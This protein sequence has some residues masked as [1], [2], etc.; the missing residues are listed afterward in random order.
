MQPMSLFAKGFR[1]FFLCAVCLAGS[2]VVYW[3]LLFLGRVPS[4]SL[5]YYPPI[6][7]H[8]H[9]MVFGYIGAVIAGFLLTAV[10]NWT[11]RITLQGWPLAILFLIWVGARV[12][13]FVGDGL[14]MYIAFFNVFFFVYL[15]ISIATP[16]IRSG[17]FR[18]L[19]VVVIVSILGLS[20]FALH[21][22]LLGIGNSRL[23]A[24]AIPIAFYLQLL[25][26]II[27]AGRVFPMFS[28]N[29]LN[30]IYS[31]KKYS[32]LEVASVLSFA[33]FAVVDIGYWKNQMFSSE[34]VLFLSLL[35]AALHTVRI[36]GWFNWRI[37]TKPLIWVLH[38]GYYFLIIGIVLI[39]I[40]AYHPEIRGLGLHA[41]L[42]GGLGL[43]TV[44]M[45]TRVTLGHTGRS[46]D[47]PPKSISI[48]F[49]LIILS[50]LA[51]VV[52]PLIDNSYYLA[53]I[54]TAAIF[55]GLGLLL[56]LA[57]MLPMLLS[58]RVDGAEG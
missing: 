6:I 41:M 19:F 2:G 30:G 10:N 36:M 43:I 35:T 56:F 47:Q 27:I 1:P 38:V 14:G 25:L 8:M 57:I 53:A 49:I 48:M 29:G 42:V 52:W 34:S 23:I 24:V 4:A 55:W 20:N 5:S 18:N 45:M 13:P 15:A 16:I 11:G 31:P 32:W 22:E 37:F 7:W 51:R 17:N 44:G 33:L 50:A 39:G 26:T 40:S 9:E 54:Q 46:I 12:L 58:A 21:A 3:T 28:A